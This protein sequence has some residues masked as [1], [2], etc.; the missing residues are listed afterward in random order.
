[1][2]ART[3][4]QARR[5]GTKAQIGDAKKYGIA[6]DPAKGNGIPTTRMAFEPKYPDRIVAAT[7]ARAADYHMV[8]DIGGKRILRTTTGSGN[9]EIRVMESIRPEDIV[10]AGR[11]AR[12]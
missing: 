9:I 7:G 11:V 2:V 4:E 3:G 6:F 1:M 12:K 10:S 8:I 5:F